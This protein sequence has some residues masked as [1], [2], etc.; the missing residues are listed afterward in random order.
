MLRGEQRKDLL[1]TDG[2]SVYTRAGLSNWSQTAWDSSKLGQQSKEFWSDP[3]GWFKG[4]P[5]GTVPDTAVIGAKAAG[6]EGSATIAIAPPAAP[7]WL[8]AGSNGAQTLKRCA[9]VISVFL[10]ST[11]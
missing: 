5:P 4:G 10:A 6:A 3:R 1:N 11:L 2:D 7:G 8:A 9:A